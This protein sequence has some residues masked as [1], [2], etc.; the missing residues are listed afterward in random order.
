MQLNR[1]ASFIAL[2]AVVLI[3]EATLPSQALAG[4][5][6]SAGAI[7]N[8]QVDKVE[9]GDVNIEP[10]FRVAIYE[11]LVEELTKAK[12]FKEVLRSGDRNAD[13]LPDLLILKTTVE[14]F[15]E[16]SETKRA[17]TTVS[18]ATKL[19]VRTQLRTPEGKTVLEREFSGNVRF[20]GGNLRATHNL[21]HNVVKA[22]KDTKLP[23]PVPLNPQLE[24]S[25]TRHPMLSAE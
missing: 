3:T 24:T 4:G 20:L 5:S 18:G 9:R 14:A 23:E 1:K 15:T 22:T 10:A 17:V 25:E 16:G 12:Q 7:W 13:C 8:L 21:A 2:A 6:G 11:N 19:K